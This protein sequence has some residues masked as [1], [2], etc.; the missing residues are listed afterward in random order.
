[1]SKERIQELMTQLHTEL[2]SAEVDQDTLQMARAL[3]VDV[4]NLIDAG[5]ANE[6]VMEQARDAEAR[7]AA[8]H[9]V[10]EK[11]IREVI[12]ILGRIGV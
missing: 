1:M 6:S 8:E 2:E 3:D 9:P 7:F 5:E 12:E 11:M 10:A 4:Q